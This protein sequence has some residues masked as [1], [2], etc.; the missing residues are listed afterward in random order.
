MQVPKC[1]KES[2]FQ[3]SIVNILSFRYLDKW[4][5]SSGTLLMLGSTSNIRFKLSYDIPLPTFAKLA[6]WEP[7]LTKKYYIPNLI[8]LETLTS[9]AF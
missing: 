8:C 9:E 2:P 6:D 1:I 3:I 5:C 7:I 4:R